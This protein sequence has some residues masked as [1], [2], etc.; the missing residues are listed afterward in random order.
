MPE[1]SYEPRFL[2]DLLYKIILLVLEVRSFGDSLD[3][4]LR[5]GWLIVWA[6]LGRAAVLHTVPYRRAGAVNAPVKKPGKCR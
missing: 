5:H 2:S 4:T 3:I 6:C 1:A